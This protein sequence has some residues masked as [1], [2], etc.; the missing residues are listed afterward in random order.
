LVP[1]GILRLAVPNFEAMANLYVENK[2]NLQQIIGPMYGRMKMDDSYIYHKTVYDK[3]S[4]S[5]LLLSA[6]F[7]NIRKWNW[8][9]VDHGQWDDHSQAYLPHMD[10]NGGTLIS[11]NIEAEK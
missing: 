11:L 3:S 9:E 1:G 7:K 4:L 2:C 6:G 10:K 8:R 5:E